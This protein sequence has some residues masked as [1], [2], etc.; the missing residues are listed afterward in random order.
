V[1]RIHTLDKAIEAIEAGEVGCQNES[2]IFHNAVGRKHSR[3]FA[4][5]EPSNHAA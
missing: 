4:D 1:G 2:K 3:A 5:A